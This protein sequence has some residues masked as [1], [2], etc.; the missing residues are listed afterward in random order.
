MQVTF[1]FGAVDQPPGAPPPDEYKTVELP[2][3][4]RVGDFVLLDD[5]DDLFECFIV[6]EV[7]WKLDQERVLCLI[8]ADRPGEATP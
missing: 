5:D 8:D 4:P 3:A 2:A 1:A 6:T 7:V